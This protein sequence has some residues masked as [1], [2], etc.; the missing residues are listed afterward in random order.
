MG[1]YDFRAIERRIHRRVW[2]QL[3]ADEELLATF[4]ARAIVR[5]GDFVPAVPFL[6]VTRVPGAD[7]RQLG[8]VAIGEW[9]LR[10]TG[11]F[12][13][14]IAPDLSLTP[15]PPPGLGATAAGVL[16]GPYRWVNTTGSAYG[17]SAVQEVQD[18]VQ[19]SAQAS[20]AAEAQTLT[21]LPTGVDVFLYRTTAGG[22]RLRFRKALLANAS[23]TF[24]DGEDE[25]S[26]D[27]LLGEEGPPINE[28]GQRVMEYVKG[29]VAELFAGGIREENGTFLTQ[30]LTTV[31]DEEPRLDESRNL[32]AVPIAVHLRSKFGIEEREP[33]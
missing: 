15:P 7:D 21:G 4:G 11:Y 13:P 23:A 10:V 12:H 28:Y 31:A 17:E 5:R 2:E 25:D 24:V 32:W 27:Q 18:M 9:R 16:T 20:L 1:L 29:L 22:S 33:R 8:D 26:A 3:A 19:L 30:A 6:A 14:E